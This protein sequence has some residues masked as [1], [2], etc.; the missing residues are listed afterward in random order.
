MWKTYNIHEK[1]QRNSILFMI[2]VRLKISN[3]N[4]LILI[5]ALSG[6][7]DYNIFNKV[8]TIVFGIDESV[9]KYVFEVRFLK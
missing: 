9:V 8:Y 6:F 2:V 7:K 5:K 1:L 4:Y 3:L